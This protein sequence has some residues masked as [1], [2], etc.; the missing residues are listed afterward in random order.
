MTHVRGKVVVPSLLH[1]GLQEEGSV[2]LLQTTGEREGGGGG[3]AGVEMACISDSG[4]H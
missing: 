4:R 2:S 1:V 3:G